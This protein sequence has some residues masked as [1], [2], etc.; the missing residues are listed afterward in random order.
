IFRGTVEAP[1]TSRPSPS[2]SWPAC[3]RGF[4][5]P[6]GHRT[7]HCEAAA[8]SPQT[9]HLLSPSQLSKLSI[10]LGRPLRTPLP[11]AS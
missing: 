5:I 11:T 6:P 4:A 3:A 1:P 7:L 10:E 8:P 9:W 2:A